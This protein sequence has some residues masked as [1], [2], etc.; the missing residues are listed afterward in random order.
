MTL[1]APH[2]LTH[3]QLIILNYLYRFRF[4][5]AH[6]FS[7]AT[8][9]NPNTINKRLALL[10]DKKY[11]GRHYKAE[12]R[13]L[14][15]PAEY[16]LLPDGISALKQKQSPRYKQTVLRNIRHDH[17]L[18]ERFISHSLDIF[19][20]YCKLKNQHKD[21]FQFFTATQ[22]AGLSY[23]P[24]KL[25]DAYL[26]LGVHK[27]PFFLDILPEHPFAVSTRRMHGYIAYVEESKQQ[28][29]QRAQTQFPTI[30][31][32][33]ENQSLQKRLLKTMRRTVENIDSQTG[34]QFYITTL[35]EL[36]NDGRWFDMAQPNEELSFADIL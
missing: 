33:C 31:L 4:A 21:S 19:Q 36:M 26:Q 22:L 12:Y 7:Q 29:E 27:K 20:I 28:W 34:L 16:Y 1:D 11:I 8:T 3:K 32:V 14:G 35:D 9:I 5:T 6:L 18:T 10:V 30:L 13:L 25:P 17:S 15:K 2:K 23:F 24:S